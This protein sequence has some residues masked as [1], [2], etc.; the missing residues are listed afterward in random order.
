MLDRFRP[1]VL[2]GFAFVSLV[3]LAG[4][5]KKPAAVVN[6][7]R[8]P[9]ERYAAALERV[10]GGPVLMQL[11]T[12]ELILQE[13]AKQK[14]APTEEA[15]AKDLAELK[16][17]NPGAL[18][19]LSDEDAKRQIRL[20]LAVKNVA[21]KG[22]TVSDAEVKKF[23][24]ENQQQF[25][26]PETLL[27][28]RAVFKTKKEAEVARATLMKANVQ[29]NVVLGKS[30]DFDNVKQNGGQLPPIVKDPK[31][32]IVMV[33]EDQSGLHAQNPEAL[34]G[35]GV[36]EKLLG[37]PEKSVSE[38]LASPAP[39]G[40][41]VIQVHQH[42]AAKTGTLAEWK[43]RIREELLLQKYLKGQKLPPGTD[44]LAFLQAQLVEKLRPQAKIEV[45]VERFKDLPQQDAAWPRTG[46]PR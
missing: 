35:K 39:E 30:I 38:V 23:F 6:G 11:I 25:N 26:Q 1:A 31:H 9:H 28:K 42:Q 17:A 2:A 3:A 37:L 45:N 43:E 14:V 44:P 8:I 27:L 7:T 22:I 24:E 16:K 20:R 12:E 5:T 19:G 40:Y 29:F 34:L 33:I 10:A 18:Q 13:A 36:A 46:A 32:G 21:F 15:V 41:Q 4:C